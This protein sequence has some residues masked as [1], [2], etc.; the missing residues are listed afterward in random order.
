MR[1]LH[2]RFLLMANPR[3]VPVSDYGLYY[4]Q[5]PGMQKACVTQVAGQQSVG[6]RR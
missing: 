1:R 6:D 5:I 4:K 2:D 3:S